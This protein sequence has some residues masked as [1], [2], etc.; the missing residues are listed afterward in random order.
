[1]VHGRRW[2][3]PVVAV[4]MLGSLLPAT[5]A[6]QQCA[7]VDLQLTDDAC[8]TVLAASVA[9]DAHG[10][11]DAFAA[12]GCIAVSGTG[13]ARNHHASGG[14]APSA[15]CTIYVGC[16]AIS[17]TGDAGNADNSSFEAGGSQWASCTGFVVCI[18]LSGTGH[19]SNGAGA[20][21]GSAG[22]PCMGFARCIAIS[23]TGDASNHAA[24]NRPCSGEY[25]VPPH[26]PGAPV[27]SSPRL[28]PGIGAG[29]VAVSGLGDASNHIDHTGGGN[30]TCAQ[31]VS[32]VAIS[33][34]AGH[35]A[36]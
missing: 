8:G 27:P 34:T 4:L 36:P 25:S 17:G 28:Y 22:Y 7:E 15:S 12:V 19:A 3:P 16:I 9:G 31:P 11:C 26:V 33:G 2:L 6:G 10:S 13:N 30:P 18:A 20:T 21:D 1:M 35:G 32:C 24:G 29:C 23:G 5:A 14:G